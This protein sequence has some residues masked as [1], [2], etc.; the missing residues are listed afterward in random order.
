MSFPDRPGVYCFKGKAGKTIYVGKAKSLKL[1]VRSYFQEPHDSFKIKS[2]LKEYKTI[3]Y[4][5]TPTELEALLLER[6]MIR[7]L[8]PYYN[9][10]LKDDKRYPY[11]KLSVNE[12]WPR[13]LLSRKKEQDGAKYYGPYE[14]RS[15]HE[16][17]RLLTRL[18]PIRR[19]KA[20]ELKPRKQPCLQYHIKRCYSPCTGAIGNA[21]YR[22]FVSAIEKLLDGNVAAAIFVLET[23]M[24]AAAG[25]KNFEIA[26][27]LRDRIRSIQRM[28]QKR[29]GWM[30]RQREKRGETGIW[31]LKRLL[32]LERNPNRIEAFDISN[33]GAVAMVASMVVFEGGVP[34]KSD[35]RRFKI[36]GVAGKPDDVAAMQEVVLRRYTKTLKSKLPKPNLVLIDGGIAQVQAGKKSL[37]QAGLNKIPILGLAKREEELFL[38]EKNVPLKVDKNS[39]ALQLLQCIRDEAHR[40]AISYHRKLRRL[41]IP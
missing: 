36:R 34:K 28:Q 17:I 29:K 20:A 33:I 23:E 38:P 15:V 12:Q 5:V 24:K 25:K 26:A 2:L 27:R 9:V 41:V 40:F 11:L 32:K 6:R 22:N 37:K 18:F 35:Y 4:I 39:P 14:G 3:N 10:L 8:K 16:T 7:K 1:R 13:L 30:P 21:E 31:E 19:C